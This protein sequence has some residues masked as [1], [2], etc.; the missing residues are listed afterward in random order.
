MINEESLGFNKSES[1]DDPI[2]EKMLRSSLRSNVEKHLDSENVVICDSM[3][4]IKGF[5][6]E[7]YC[8]A[9]NAQTT[10]TVIFCD[11]KEE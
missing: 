6:Y 1:Y 10:I 3:N 11:V 9:R 8:L 7:L 2:H 4:Y 5:R